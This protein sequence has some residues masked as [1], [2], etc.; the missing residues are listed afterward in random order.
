M[1]FWIVQGLGIFVLFFYFLSFQMKEKENLLTM[2]IISNVFS[3]TQYLLTGAGALTGAIQTIL[4][5]I[6]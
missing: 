6:R 1:T 5:I 4:G 2:Q 3:A